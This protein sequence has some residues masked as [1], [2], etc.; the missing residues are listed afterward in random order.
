MTDYNRFLFSLR[1]GVT[2]KNTGSNDSNGS[3]QG[4]VFKNK[5]QTLYRSFVFLF[6]F[7]FHEVEFTSIMKVSCGGS[8]QSGGVG[9]LRVSLKARFRDDCT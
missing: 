6:C 9:I 2:H 7:F 1:F 8:K 4:C 3:T 5:T